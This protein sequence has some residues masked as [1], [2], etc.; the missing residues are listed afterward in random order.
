MKDFKLNQLFDLIIIPF[1]SLLHLLTDKDLSSCFNCIK[2]H[3]SNNGVLL[4]D[5][6]VPNPELLYRNP[7]KKYKEMIIDHPDVGRCDVWQKS[8]YDQK[9][10]IN[11]INWIFDINNNQNDKY[12]FEMRMLYPDTVDR[13]LF[14][15]GFLIKQK[16]GD[17]DGRSFNENSLLQIYVCSKK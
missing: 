12:Q 6:F 13:L 7:N 11:K 2:N 3:L 4:I 14:E 1:N 9:T 10:E 15:T 5:I 8:K 16:L 17:Y